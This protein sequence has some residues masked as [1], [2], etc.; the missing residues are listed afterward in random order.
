LP[1]VHIPDIEISGPY[2]QIK[3]AKLGNFYKLPDIHILDIE[4]F[5]HHEL[6]AHEA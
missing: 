4:N 6:P 5:F 2:V 1:D 3:D